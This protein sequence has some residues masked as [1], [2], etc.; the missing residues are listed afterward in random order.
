MGL[1]EKH[2]MHQMEKLELTQQNQMSFLSHPLK[3][4]KQCFFYVVKH[5][6]G[7]KKWGSLKMVSG[8]GASEVAH[9]KNRC[10]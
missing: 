3:S 8:T 2:I 4:C 1:V 7:L 5:C 6:E 10:D 9:N